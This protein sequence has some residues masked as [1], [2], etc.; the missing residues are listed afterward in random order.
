MTK[1]ISKMLAIATILSANIACA[2]DFFIIG[3]GSV[4]G[5]YYPTGSSICR[6]VAKSNKN[7]RCS[8]EMTSGSIQNIQQII[9][10]QLEVAVSQGDVLHEAYHGIARF[11]SPSK[12]LRTIMM[13]HSELLSIIVSRDAKISTPS[14]LKGKRISLGSFDDGSQNTPNAILELLNIK[15]SDLRRIGEITPA[16]TKGAM[17][18]GRIDGYF[19]TIGHPAQSIANLA[20]SKKISLLNLEQKS[21]EDITKK[22]P[23]YTKNIISANT[24]NGIDRDIETVGVRAVLVASDKTDNNIVRA[25]VKSV[26]D[27]FDDFRRIYPAYRN[28]TKQDLIT[29][30]IVPLHPAA[31]EVYKK[32]GILK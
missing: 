32:A 2:M 23:Y 18:D 5:V 13:L 17:I 22:Y 16:E 1:M 21:I 9:N 27:N 30:L 26:L 3:T 7:M 12:N 28:L 14:D 10:D 20:L 25:I 24:Y 19:T 15:R 29:D 8:A 6:I 4:T 31:E 11:Q